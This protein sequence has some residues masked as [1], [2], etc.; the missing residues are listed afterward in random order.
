M[1]IGRVGGIKMKME[2]IPDCVHVANAWCC[3]LVRGVVVVLFVLKGSTGFIQYG[4]VL[5]IRLLIFD[6]AF[7]LEFVFS[8]KNG[9]GGLTRMDEVEG[10]GSKV[11][12]DQWGIWS[13]ST[14]TRSRVDPIFSTRA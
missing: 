13:G 12:G 11:P 10:R 6:R 8:Q 7:L 4:R 1:L 5:R 3:G 2:C 14:R 9:C